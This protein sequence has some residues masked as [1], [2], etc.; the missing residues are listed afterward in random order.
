[1]PPGMTRLDL[2]GAPPFLQALLDAE[3]LPAVVLAHAA[4]RPDAP[5]LVLERDDRAPATVTYAALA[6]RA[7]GY[8]AAFRAR[9]LPPGSLVA[10]LLVTHPDLAPAFLG[11]MMAGLIPS[12][13]PPMSPRIDPA[14]FWPAQRSVLRGIDPAMIVTDARHAAEL[15][16]FLP[17]LATPIVDVDDGP[18][19]ARLPAPLAAPDGIAFL[20]HSSGTT[21]AKKGVILGHRAVLDFAAALATALR[22]RPDDVI[23]SWLPLYHDMGLIGC[24]VLP[25]LL[26]LTIV[27]LDPFDWVTRPVSLFQAIERHRATLCWMPNFA[28]HHLIR[29]V[30]ADA[31]HDLSSMRAFIDCSEPCKPETLALFRDRFA[32]CGLGRHALQV[33]YGMAENVFIATQTDMTADP[34]VVTADREAYATERTIRDAAPGAPALSFLAVG[35]PI[36]GTR[37]RILGD[38]GATLGE[39]R[40]G[41]IAVASPYLFDGYFRRPRPATLTDDGWYLTGDLGFTLDGEV[42]VCGRMDDLL[43]VN[44]RNIYA[45]DVEYL[46]NRETAVKPGRCVAVGP[47]NPRA[48]SQALVVIAESEDADEAARQALRRQIRSLVQA[49][50]G[51]TAHDVRIVAP[52]WLVKTTSGKI[53][54]EANLRRYAEDAAGAAGG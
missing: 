27:Q 29:T 14:V 37:I 16:R 32:A 28:F 22:V 30:P 23:V 54:R 26:G 24:L 52:G 19:E 51:V 18:G 53:S 39:R 6:D 50:F 35:A 4:A 20:Q 43:I 34:R 12:L 48:G 46:I 7:R 38:D 3:D 49:G 45:H 42:F 40:V 13:F 11:A 17:E 31:R 36:P 47:F 41:Q 5:F 9:G 21:G 1:M 25:M 8:A 10:L 2:A 15:R 33:S 44:G